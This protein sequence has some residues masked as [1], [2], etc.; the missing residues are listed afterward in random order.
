MY[1][2]P[3]HYR[4]GLLDLLR[5][6]FPAARQHLEQALRLAPDHR[7]V[8]KALAYCYVWLGLYEDAFPLLQGIP[9]ARSEMEAYGG[10]WSIQGRGDL[11]AQ[12]A[13]MAHLLP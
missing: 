9:E 11:A 8:R 7:G 1:N 2:F 10:W 6:D 13:Q 4:Q 5:R 3:A 12:A